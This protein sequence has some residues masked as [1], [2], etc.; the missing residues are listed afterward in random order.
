MRSRSL[1][2]PIWNNCYLEKDTKEVEVVSN[3][4]NNKMAVARRWCKKEVPCPKAFFYYDQYMYGVNLSDQLVG[5]YDMDKKSLK[6]WKRMLYDCR[7]FMGHGCIYRNSEQQE[8]FFRFFIP[9]SR[10]LNCV[11]KRA[12]LWWK[13]VNMVNHPYLRKFYWMLDTICQWKGPTRRCC[14]NCSISKKETRIT[15]I[16]TAWEVSLCIRCLSVYHT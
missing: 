5:L 14:Q 11:W 9:S 10:I 7:E 12:R 6:W 4:R 8:K 2:K 3:C 16:C 1:L 15:T 13:N